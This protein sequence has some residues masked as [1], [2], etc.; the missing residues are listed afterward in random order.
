MTATDLLT[1]LRVRC[2]RLQPSGGGLSV[3]APKGALTPDLVEALREHKA[4]LLALLQER[5][6]D[7]LTGIS[8]EVMEAGAVPIWPVAWKHPLLCQ[9]CGE[10]PWGAAGAALRC[11]W[12]QY[13]EAGFP[14]PRLVPTEAMEEAA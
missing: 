3:R 4:D 12:C 14:V 1:A 6:A 13:R 10:V 5:A 7:H 8:R 2:I 9:D 11:P